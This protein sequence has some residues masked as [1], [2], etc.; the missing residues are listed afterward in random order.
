MISTPLVSI[1]I[2]AYH[3]Q[4]R[5]ARAVKSIF[6]QDYSNWE[7]VIIS[8]DGCDYERVLADQGIR[9]DKIQFQSSGLVGSGAANAR[10]IGLNHAKGD[11]IALLDCDD[12][13][14]PTYLSEMLRLVKKYGAA[15]SQISIIDEAS[16]VSIPLASELIDS[17]VMLP[18]EVTARAMHTYIAVVFNKEIINHSFAP[19][20]RMAD[21]VFLMQMFNVVDCIGFF[22]KPSY[23]YYKFFGTST[24][25]AREADIVA[26]KFIEVF[27]VIKQSVST[28]AIKI[29]NAEIK[30]IIND[31]MDMLI[32]AENYFMKIARDNPSVQFYEIL[33]D[34][35][36]LW[37]ST[38][39]RR[40]AR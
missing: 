24:Q 40:I 23:R 26:Q 11:V 30:N 28:G 38:V 32:A 3:G 22:A 14:E 34:F 13:C 25:F 9:S 20:E 39:A 19:L 18:H 36:N 29:D 15:F 7:I 27:E 1:I 12:E 35:T 8:D 5:I 6:Q 17:E 31:D 16:G 4:Q 21:Y 10:N 37:R 33:P 2:P